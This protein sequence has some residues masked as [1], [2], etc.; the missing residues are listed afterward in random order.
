MV[1]VTLINLIL[2]MVAIEHWAA[3]QV[4]EFSF[5]YPI[6]LLAVTFAEHLAFVGTVF[7]LL[8]QWQPCVICPTQCATP[9]TTTVE[10]TGSTNHSIVIT[11]HFN[12]KV[13]LALTFPEMAKMITLLL[14]TWDSS[15]ML[16]FVT[17]GLCLVFQYNSFIVAM[18]YFQQQKASGCTAI[19]I[20]AVLAK[21]LT[22]LFFH[23]TAELLM[24]GIIT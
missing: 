2:K 14:Q 22:R 15:P 3:E 5:F 6:Y 21:I 10:S 16:F 17:G 18:S 1:S 4:E 12:R 11:K 13:Y 20:S 19:F 8:R 7:L 9:S 24:L 23:S